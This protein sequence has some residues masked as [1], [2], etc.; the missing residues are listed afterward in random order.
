MS[1]GEQQRVAIA[2]ALAM[3]PEA[4]L[5]DEPT[6]A[7]DPE[8]VGDLVALLDRLRSEGLTMVTVTHEMRFA[9]ALASRVLVL[10]GGHIIEQGAPGDV[11]TNPR[12]ERTRAF[13]GFG[14]AAAS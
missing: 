14:H 4:L 12:H 13:L 1:G 3:E 7:L 10:H 8:R 2:R 9:Q 11:L 5:L 6:S